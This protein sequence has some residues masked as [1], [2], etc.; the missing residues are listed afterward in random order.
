LRLTNAE[1]ATGFR[2][3]GTAGEALLSAV[4]EVVGQYTG[5][6]RYLYSSRLKTEASYMQ[7]LETGRCPTLMLDDLVACTIVVPTLSDI[8]PCI[9]TLP[10]RIEVS[11]RKGPSSRSKEPDVFRF[12]DEQLICRLAPPT[13]VPIT[14]D[15]IWGIP[16]EIQVKT[17]TQYAWGQATHGLVYKGDESD[18]RRERLSAQLRALAEQAD[19]LYA[20]FLHVSERIPPSQS[21]R[22]SDL[23]CVS[24][25]LDSWRRHGLVSSAESPPSPVRFA[26]SVVDLCRQIGVGASRA[27]REATVYMRRKGKPLSLSV[28]QA[29]A[30]VTISRRVDTIR[31]DRVAGRYWLPLTQEM[32][33]GFPDLKR[34]P[35]S[36]CIAHGPSSQT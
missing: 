35:T 2:R 23:A 25:Y 36:V 17:V 31:W 12:D 5:Q 28:F 24:R 19:L 11:K 32:I 6:R 9:N 18:W 13:G 30:S 20:E 29:L 7:K 27:C 21:R 22:S 3:G 26:E 16:F 4:D 8:D 33:D 14:G 34:V 10:D 1:V 15:S